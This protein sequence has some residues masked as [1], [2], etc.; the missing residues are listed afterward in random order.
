MTQKC[1]VKRAGPKF[2][3]KFTGQHL[4]CSAFS[5]SL[6]GNTFKITG[7]GLHRKYFPVNVTNISLLFCRIS[8]KCCFSISW[9]QRFE[10][11]GYFITVFF[12]NSAFVMLNFFYELSLKCCL[13]VMFLC[14]VL[15]CQALCLGVFM[16]YLFD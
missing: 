16:S 3:V 2:L 6:H 7:K 14:L 9:S 8:I 4:R 13:G 5:D 15:L 10:W 11:H 12:F 1:F